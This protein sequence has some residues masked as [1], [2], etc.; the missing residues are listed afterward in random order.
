MTHGRTGPVLRTGSGGDDGGAER[1]I[2]P[3]RF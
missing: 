2:S 3:P 1:R